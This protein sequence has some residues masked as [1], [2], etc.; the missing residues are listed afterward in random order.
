[1]SDDPCLN[2]IEANPDID[3][4][5]IRVSL[6]IQ[7]TLTLLIYAISPDNTTFDSWWSTLVTALSLQL[8]AL[9][10]WKTI[11]LYHAIL[12]SW[13]SFPALIMS[14]SFFGMYYVEGDAPIALLLLTYVHTCIFLAFTIWVWAVVPTFT[15][16]DMVHLVL[17]GQHV[18]VNGWIRYI[19]LFLLGL[20]ALGVAVASVLGF[21]FFLARQPLIQ[22][23]SSRVR[24]FEAVY[25]IPPKDPEKVKRTTRNE[26]VL[27][28]AFTAFAFQVFAS[29]MAELMISSHQILADDDNP[30]GFGQIVA[31]I[32]LITPVFTVIRVIRDDYMGKQKKPYDQR[33]LASMWRHIQ[34]WR[35]GVK[36]DNET[37]SSPGDQKSLSTSYELVS[38]TGHSREPSIS[39]NPSFEET[40]SLRP[41][42]SSDHGIEL[43]R[44]SSRRSATLDE[45]HKIEDNVDKAHS[46]S[47][48][49]ADHNPLQ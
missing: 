1:M 37:S 46:P 36:I 40:R 22:K 35:K 44:R 48:S 17:V 26:R 18:R 33:P 23:L 25:V 29:V 21:L 7:A 32:L 28:G 6:Y 10:S 27:G 12:V 8:A 4:I 14:F 30:W 19:V 38:N 45:P 43:S 47:S 31:M 16:P 13:L 9:A 15:C 49:S 20:W 34:A 39:S 42:N 3:G 24:D 2:P 5:G 11:T 41:T